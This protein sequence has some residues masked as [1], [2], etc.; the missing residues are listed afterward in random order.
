M[1]EKQKRVMISINLGLGMPV[2]MM[3]GCRQ[4]A[5]YGREST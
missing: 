2:S 1:L 5:S 3:D 4:V